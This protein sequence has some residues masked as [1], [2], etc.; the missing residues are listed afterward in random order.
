M[1]RGELFRQGVPARSAWSAGLVVAVLTTGLAGCAVGPD[2]RTPQPPDSQAYTT[3]SQ[4]VQ[5]AS[6]EGVAQHYIVGQ[7]IPADWWNVFHSSHLNQLIRQALAANPGI[8][9]ADAALRQAQEEVAA[10][11]GYFY[12]TA[13]IGYSLSRQQLAGNM[14]GNSPG[15]QGNGSVVSVTNNASPPYV[16]PIIYNWHTANLSVG[17]TPDVF[18]SN[19][20]QVESLQAQAD[21]QHFQLEAARITLVANLVAAALQE[22]ALAE[23]LKAARQV[24][25]DN[26]QALDILKKQF[27][28]GY[29]M[30]MDVAA[31]ESALAAAEAVLPPLD[32]QLEQT[33]DLIR[34]LVGKPQDQ[35][36]GPDFSMAEFS[37]PSALPLS[38]PADLV[39]QRPDVRVAEA[40]LHAASA[41]VGVAIA[42]RLPQFSINGVYGGEATE[43]GQMF[44][45]GGPFWMLLGNV[46]QPVFDGGT[47]LHRK[48]AADQA[49]VQ[50]A[51]QYRATVLAALQNVAD[52]LHAIRA[53]ADGLAAADRAE[54][55]A[56]ITRDLTRQQ[57]ESGYVSALV[58]LQAEQAWQQA[59][60]VQV[61]AQSQRLGDTAALYEALGGGWWQRPVVH[62]HP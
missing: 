12:P 49:L 1:T 52:T 11:K 56:R 42:A 31:Q 50:A 35:S 44:Q 18:G 9:A 5:T 8:A 25:S 13:S 14:G 21:A 32:K 28:T 15:L 2:F 61:Q 16:K 45:T 53:D 19:S 10:Q 47:L 55:A 38:L 58:W 6:A 36:V 39:R 22:A 3:H 17:Y 7:D 41:N 33:R 57:Q 27:A 30:R 60:M 46:T 20:R 26:R 43:F 29:V 23:Q 4:P 37:L 34:V 48:R 62:K 40:Q 51:A 59:R 24:V 54:R